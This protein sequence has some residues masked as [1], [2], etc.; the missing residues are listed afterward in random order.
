MPTSEELQKLIAAQLRDAKAY[1]AEKSKGYTDTPA[2][3]IKPADTLGVNDE[4]RGHH[5][6]Q[7]SMAERR[8]CAL[9]AMARSKQSEAALLYEAAADIRRAWNVPID[10]YRVKQQHDA[11]VKDYH[12][13]QERKAS[14]DHGSRSPQSEVREKGGD[15][16]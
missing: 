2:A 13:Q 4:L 9:E 1:E 14:Q 11:H 3:Q 5:D 10:G 12:A 15:P 16:F 6:P 7:Q 8:A